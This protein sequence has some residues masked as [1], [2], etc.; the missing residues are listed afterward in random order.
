MKRG[1]YLFS[2]AAAAAVFLFAPVPSFKLMR[3]LH[4]VGK[5]GRNLS[6][7]RT[8]KANASFCLANTFFRLLL[9]LL[10]FFSIDSELKSLS[11]C[12]LV[13]EVAMGGGGGGGNRCIHVLSLSLCFV[14]A[15]SAVGQERERKERRKGRTNL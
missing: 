15:A 12:L 1:S 10:P 2:A 9:L 13:Q 14:A 7:E 3:L 8:E 11:L 4:D 6:S 5:R